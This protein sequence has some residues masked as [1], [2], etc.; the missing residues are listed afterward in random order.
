[1]G[2]ANERTTAILEKLKGANE[3][4]FVT[5]SFLD[6][7]LLQGRMFQVQRRIASIAVTTPYK[8]CLDLSAVPLDYCVLIPPLTFSATGGPVVIKTYRISSYSDGTSFPSNRLNALSTNNIYAK[9]IVKYNITSSDTAGDDLRE[10]ELGA[11]GNPQQVN[12][13]GQGSGSSVFIV[14]PK[15]IIA[16]EIV[17]NYSEAVNFTLSLLWAEVPSSLFAAV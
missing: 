11:T 12:R 3:R 17:N 4:S 8:C 5:S 16:L 9:G 1:M 13:S 6:D 14:P 15:I 2:G 7:F 10:Y